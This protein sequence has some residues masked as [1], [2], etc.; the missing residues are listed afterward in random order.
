MLMNATA[1]RIRDN[2]DPVPPPVDDVHRSICRQ[3]KFVWSSMIRRVDLYMQ[4]LELTGMQWEPVLMLWLK[5]ADTVAG[6]ARVSQMGVA[7]MTRP[8]LLMYRYAPSTR[9][10]SNGS[11]SSAAFVKGC[12]IRRDELIRP[13][14]WENAARSKWLMKT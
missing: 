2:T 7:S 5:R 9:A 4:P 14:Y 11:G 13:G 1:R 12:Q 10:T 3:L 8:P 6:L